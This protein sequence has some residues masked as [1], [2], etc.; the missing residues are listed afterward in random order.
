VHVVTPEFEIVI[1]PTHFRLERNVAGLHHRLDLKIKPRVA[2]STF[3]VPPH[4][5]IGQAWDGDG[6]AIDGEQDAWPESG[7][8]TTYAM[9][10]GAIEGAPSDY[11]VAT[12]Y[13]TD[14]KYS[15]FDATS[16]EPRNVAKLV[17]AGLLN[18]PKTVYGGETVGSTEPTEENM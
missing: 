9:A 1:T 2:E 14:F 3:A 17:A 16:A 11:K 4:G 7:E 12:K 13:A 15:R 10:K 8:F 5:I 18:A 6:K